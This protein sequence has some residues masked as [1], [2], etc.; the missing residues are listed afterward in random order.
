M[1]IINAIFALIAADVVLA[2]S[3][4]NCISPDSRT[5]L[6]ARNSKLTCP[7]VQGS[8]QDASQY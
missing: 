7:R 8:V 5:I 2:N 1:G 4:I 3:K 6:I